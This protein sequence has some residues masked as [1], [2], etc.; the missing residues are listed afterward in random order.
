MLGHAPAFLIPPGPS[1]L[2]EGMAVVSDT[3]V[4]FL[5]LSFDN[6]RWIS[7]PLGLS[8]VRKCHLLQMIADIPLPPKLSFLIFAFFSSALSEKEKRNKLEIFP[9]SQMCSL[10]LHAGSIVT[11]WCF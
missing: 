8:G 5:S 1:L 4:R 10:M 3:Y 6:Q 9:F 2:V 11:P 7:V